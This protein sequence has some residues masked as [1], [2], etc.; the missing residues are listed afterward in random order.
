V[1]V[2]SGYVLT[3]GGVALALAGAVRLQRGV[4]ERP[5]WLPLGALVFVAYSPVWRFTTGGLE[6]GLTFAWLGACLL[7]LATWASHDG[8]LARWQAIV[9]GLGPL[10]RP[11]LLVF[12]IGFVVLVLATQWEHDR[13]RDRVA[14]V[15]A[16]I[17]LPLAYE[18]FRM[19][20]YASL[21]PNTAIAKEAS[22]SYWSFGRMYL[23]D[24]VVHSYALWIPLVI[25]L[26][27]AYVP[28]VWLLRRH[29]RHRAVWVAATFVLA[30]LLVAFYVVRVGGDFMPARLLLPSLFAVVAPVAV[31]PATRQFA[32][33]LL[34]IPWAIVAIVTLRSGID[35]PGFGIP[36]NA[37]TADQHLGPG[38]AARF[39]Q[40]GVYVDFRRIPGR[41]RFDDRL[42]AFYGVGATSYALGPD[43]YVLDLLG[44]GD[45]FTAHLRLHRRTVVAHEKPLPA[46]WIAARLVAP[47][48][49]LRA[50]DFPRP[51]LTII[52]VDD[53]DGE[54][55]AQRVA[56][57]RH[58]LQCERLRDFVAS[59]DAPLDAGRFVDN[60]SAAFS[61]FGLRIPPEPRDAVKKFC[62]R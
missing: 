9:L 47:G 20:Y 57:A 49:P 54:P 16:A 39:A 43:V 56:D 12:S 34:V 2:L 59:Y 33:A 35:I 15:V 13:R 8:V 5:V 62:A 30:G 41:P 29:A 51:F 55:F 37:V 48:T 17:A 58:A 44:L 40:P 19:G 11:E 26:V 25:L 36:R 31:V 22:R 6:N 50:S 38:F 1:A 10:V 23:S 60:L 4:V 7:L 32:G 14:L 27:G 46:P 18:I 53:P 42:P 28:M 45:A 21:V 3:L 24:A 61:N 52:G